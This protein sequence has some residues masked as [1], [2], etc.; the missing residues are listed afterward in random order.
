MLLSIL[1]MMIIA[2]VLL[3][4][5]S[6]SLRTTE[7]NAAFNGLH[8][9]G[10]ALR[11]TF[12]QSM[13]QTNNKDQIN[14]LELQF[15][16]IKKNSGY[17]IT[18]FYGDKRFITTLKDDNGIREVGTKASSVVS[19]RVLERGEDYK[20]TNINI[21]GDEYVVYYIPMYDEKSDGV[22]GMVFIGIPRA[23]IMS[24]FIRS[25]LPIIAITVAI[26][27]V[28]LIILL[29]FL[30]RLIM[31][32][33][34]GIKV[35]N[36]IAD[37]NLKVHFHKR[38]L[39][40][41]DEIGDIY[42]SAKKL[43]DILTTVISD[44]KESSKELIN[45][46]AELSSTS[47]TVAVTV[48][49]LDTTIQ[50][51]SSTTMVQSADTQNANEKIQ[52][53]GIKINE[54]TQQ[55]QSLNVTTKEM[56]SATHEVLAKLDNLN[57]TMQQT[58]EAIISISKQTIVTNESVRKINEVTKVITD[59]ADQTTLLSLNASIEAA[60]AG[61]SGKGFAV[62]AGEIQSLAEQSNESAKKIENILMNLKQESDGAVQLIEG[63]KSQIS[64][65]ENDISDTE[66]AF[67]D[68][69]V[70]IRN[71]ILGIN[72]ISELVQVLDENK[73]G[74]LEAVES[75]AG[76]AQENAASTEETAASFEEVSHLLGNVA[77]KSSEL[78]NLADR[79]NK[80]IEVFH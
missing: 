66:H 76:I 48:G 20:D 53:I 72:T 12:D 67:E 32:I 6:I 22:I 39:E 19:K 65:Q 37:C 10:L 62:V 43:D 69:R 7:Y 47:S 36:R 64:E 59:I 71:S 26:F 77:S 78:K 5:M 18:I 27:I 41:K 17:D 21:L 42:R 44:V 4:G 11:D 70:K 8:S 31:A 46:S 51:I 13:F 9:T 63:V 2:L 68:V 28:T 40:R 35:I 25:V 74:T 14:L 73:N 29:P 3:A 16:N 50:E 34:N 54:T 52:V 24:N 1:P 45:S 79:L 38:E 56:R 75:L 61:E 23:I 30:K 15:D 80:S 57:K 55:L 60:R 49:E 58:K 33:Q